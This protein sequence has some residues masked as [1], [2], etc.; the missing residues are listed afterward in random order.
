MQVDDHKASLASRLC[1]ELG[2]AELIDATRC[3]VRLT[4]L[5]CMPT[6]Q[7]IF[8]MGDMNSAEA[9]LATRA[10]NQVCLID[11][12]SD[13]L[14]ARALSCLRS[15]FSHL[16]SSFVWRAQA[17]VLM[18]NL[19]C[20]HHN[21][22][23]TAWKVRLASLLLS[24]ADRLPC[25]RRRSAPSCAADLVCVRRAVRCRSR[26]PRDKRR[27]RSARSVRDLPVRFSA[28]ATDLFYRVLFLFT[29]SGLLCSRRGGSGGVHHGG[30][31]QHQRSGRRLPLQG[32]GQSADSRP[33]W[34]LQGVRFSRFVTL[35]PPLRTCCCCRPC[36]A[37]LDRA[38]T[39]C[40]KCSKWT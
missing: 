25:L 28:R 34:D 35:T 22:P 24:R 27:W 8:A 33:C 38:C 6:Q 26:T 39:P 4:F 14:G 11:R 15:G 36:V 23:L 29:L 10:V 16:V 1:A 40:G 13:R 32:S 31:A 7:N 37:W 9:T 17:Y 21:L 18:T 12:C 3:A 30:Q 19:L 5:S 20:S 2:Q